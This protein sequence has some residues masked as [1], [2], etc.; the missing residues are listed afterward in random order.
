MDLFSPGGP[1]GSVMALRW[2]HDLGPADWLLRSPVPWARLVGLGPDGFAAYVRLRFVPDP[3]RP[4]QSE[5]D[6]DLPYDR[7]SDLDEARRALA[8]LAG[9]TSTPDDCWFAVWEGYG[10]SIEVPPALP[11][12]DLVDAELGSVRRYA[13]LR[14]RL[15]DL[16]DW[17]RDVGDGLLVPPAFVWPADHRWCLAA[18][19]DPHWAGIGAEEA[20]VAA[21]L[22][23]PGLDVV[24]TDPA[25]TQPHH[26]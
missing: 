2:S 6:Q 11:L 10:G 9:F 4:G 17:E 21:L 26:S 14:G 15:D 8:V 24:R 5:A 20:A 19:V 1:Y 22:G 25:Q 3:V 23:T 7:P 16:Q 13:L 12:L 18:D